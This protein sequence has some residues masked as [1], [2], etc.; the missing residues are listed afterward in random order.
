MKVKDRIL[1]EA[2]KAFN[3]QGIDNVS[4]YDIAKKL[5]IRQSHI[6]YY[7]PAKLHLVNALAKGMIYEINE[8]LK[9]IVTSADSFSFKTYYTLVEDVMK[10]H[11]K[12]KFI[13]LNYANIITNDKELNTYYKDL[14]FN[15]RT[16]EFEGLI[17]LLEKN[18]YITDKR[19]F[20]NNDKIIMYVGN[21]LAIYWIQESAIYHAEKTEK[22]QRKHHLK[23]FFQTYVPYLTTKGK[24]QLDQLLK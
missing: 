6:T 23:V 7:F 2:L 3:K 20:L 5:K 15:S 13:L 1:A 19:Y 24:K 8:N 10:V 12:Y 21:I 16:K 14:L 11:Q 17:I 18:G 4:T 9:P 22:A